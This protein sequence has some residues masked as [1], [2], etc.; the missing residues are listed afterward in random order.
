MAGL[1][2]TGQGYSLSA[3][4]LVIQDVDGLIERMN[5]LERSLT[6][7]GGERPFPVKLTSPD[8]YSG[9]PNVSM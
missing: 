3:P 1:V 9:E 2:N 7:V 8:K 5:N 4:A 6:Q